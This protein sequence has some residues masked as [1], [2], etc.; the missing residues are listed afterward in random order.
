MATSI[1]R[2]LPSTHGIL[3]YQF[4]DGSPCRCHNAAVEFQ[5]LA[6]LTNHADTSEKRVIAEPEKF[7]PLPMVRL[8]PWYLIL[9]WPCCSYLLL[10]TR[11]ASIYGSGRRVFCETRL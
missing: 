5:V 4:A 11:I 1:G 2:S 6:P 9:M 10:V 7:R 8:I 3:C